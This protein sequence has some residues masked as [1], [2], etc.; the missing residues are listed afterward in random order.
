[1]CRQKTAMSLHIVRKI[2]QISKSLLQPQWLFL[3]L[4]LLFIMYE[5]TKSQRKSLI[6]FLDSPNT[7]LGKYE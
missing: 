7:E 3:L 5:G 2:P 4:T 1:M 6:S